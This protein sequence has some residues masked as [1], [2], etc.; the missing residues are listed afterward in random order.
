VLRAKVRF[1]VCIIIRVRVRVRV[2]HLD[3]EN[4]VQH[5]SPLRVLVSD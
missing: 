2:A 4:G 3:L 5:P 1:R